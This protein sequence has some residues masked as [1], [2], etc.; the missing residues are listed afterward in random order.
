MSLVPVGKPLLT[1]VPVPGN[2]EEGDDITLICGIPKGSPPISFRFYA[3]SHTPIHTTTVQS[4][5]SSFVLNT[6]NRENSGNY[7]CDASNMEDK[8]SSNIVTVEGEFHLSSAYKVSFVF[9]VSKFPIKSQ[10][11]ASRFLSNQVNSMK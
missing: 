8:P 6:V 2:I 1:V 5:S 3:S 10:P 7:Y 11:F 4:N 9:S